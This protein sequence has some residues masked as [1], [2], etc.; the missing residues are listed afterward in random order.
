MEKLAALDEAS[1]VEPEFPYNM[2]S[3]DMVRRLMYGGMRDRIIL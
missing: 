2:F 1:R 3:K